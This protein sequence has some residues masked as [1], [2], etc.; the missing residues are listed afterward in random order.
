MAGLRSGIFLRARVCLGAHDMH[1]DC[2]EDSS[3]TYSWVSIGKEAAVV[4]KG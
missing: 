4:E 3:F 2:R 1:Q